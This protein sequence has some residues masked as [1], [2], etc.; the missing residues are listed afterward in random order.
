MVLVSGQNEVLYCYCLFLMLGNNV[1]FKSSNCRWAPCR[2]WKPKKGINLS[3]KKL[4]SFLS[5]IARLRL[6]SGPSVRKSI[7]YGC[8]VFAESKFLVKSRNT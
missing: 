5:I 2:E 8:R 7:T 1:C 4:K 6:Y 3:E